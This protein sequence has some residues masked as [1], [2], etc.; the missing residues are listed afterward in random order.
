MGIDERIVFY[1]PECHVVFWFDRIVSNTIK[2]V[3]HNFKANT[4][5]DSAGINLDAAIA[6]CSA[7]TVIRIKD[8]II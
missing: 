7:N 5:L 3:A 6:D 4:R 2:G 8:L 1:N